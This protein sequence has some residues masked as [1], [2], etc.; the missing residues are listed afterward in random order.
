MMRTVRSIFVAAALIAPGCGG[1]SSAAPTTPT[2]PSNVLAV[3]GTYATRAT[4]IADRNTCGSVTVQDNPTTVTHTAG[5]S[6]ISLSHAGSTYRGSID[7]AAR[8]STP[9]ANFPFP[10]ADYTIS[11]NGQF[12]TTG[13]TGTVELIKRVGATTC[14]YAVTWVGTKQG[15]PNTIPS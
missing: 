3:A 4:V 11:I 12:S 13:F 2:T 5:G 1:G 7:T 15:T 8:F 6:E 10:D 9:A 14:T